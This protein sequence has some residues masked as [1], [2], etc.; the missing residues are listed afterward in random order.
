MENPIYFGIAVYEEPYEMTD[1]NGDGFQ[2]SSAEEVEQK[3]QGWIEERSKEMYR[4]RKYFNTIIWEL[5][6]DGSVSL[7][8]YSVTKD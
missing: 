5:H 1:I 3:L 7:D 6:P 2:G 8:G 4:E